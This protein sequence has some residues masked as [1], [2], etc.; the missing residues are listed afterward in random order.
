MRDIILFISF[1]IC[2]GLGL[3]LM[4]RPSSSRN[5]STF[6][7]SRRPTSR[8]STPAPSQPE[9][10]I[11]TL[12]VLEVPGAEFTNYL[13][14]EDGMALY[15]DSTAE[16]GESS[17]YGQCLK[18]F[19]PALIKLNGSLGLG[20]QLN[21]EKVGFVKRSDGSQQVAYNNYALFYFKNDTDRGDTKGQGHNN[22]WF[23]VDMLG[24]PYKPGRNETNETDRPTND[25]VRSGASSSSSS[26]PPSLGKSAK[27]LMVPG[28]ASMLVVPDDYMIHLTVNERNNNQS[29]MTMHNNIDKTVR[30]LKSIVN[31]V[32][33][34]DLTMLA[35]DM[36]VING[37]NSLSYY[38][39]TTTND[40]EK[41]E[42]LATAIAGLNSQN[43]TV[44]MNIGNTV[45]SNTLNNLRRNLLQ[46]AMKNSLDTAYDMVG[47]L[48]KTIDQGR[49]I[50]SLR[51]DPDS[52]KDFHPY[53]FGDTQRSQLLMKM[54]GSSP[55]VATMKVLVD[56]NL[57]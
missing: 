56:Y 33:T 46:A 41:I 50:Y 2:I 45:S 16:I 26:S 57:K 20:D 34:T 24:I 43:R 21:E 38:Y 22:T 17:C 32:G 39:F 28:Y 48:N 52:V 53:Y 11:K 51:M 23:L 31:R 13:T 5:P 6:S 54:E 27:T 25:T 47:S 3:G 19:T 8:P 55:T 12:G 1:Y 4:Q 18:L 15:M 10:N 14:N 42:R 49:P 44:I 37:L 35:K 30:D 40:P 29:Y 7:S 36:R 9:P